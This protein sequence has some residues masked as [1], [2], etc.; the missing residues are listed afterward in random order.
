MFNYK[1]INL[2]LHAL[3]F[4]ANSDSFKFHLKICYLACV[5]ENP[6]PLV[7]TE[8]KPPPKLLRPANKVWGKVMFSE[9]LVSQQG[10]SLYDV[11]SCLAGGSLWGSLWGV[12]GR[13]L[14]PGVS[15]WGRPPQTE[16]SPVKVWQLKVKFACTFTLLTV[17]DSDIGLSYSCCSRS[18]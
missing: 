8:Q 11:T 13:D 12:S 1:V 15:V 3:K 14:C 7:E 18:V 2:A 4:N 16:T 17:P 6:I 9:A 5:H 10:G